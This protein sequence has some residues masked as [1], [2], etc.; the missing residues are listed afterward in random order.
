MRWEWLLVPIV[1]F[2]VT[3][4]GAGEALSPYTGQDKREIRAL[5]KEEVH[6]YLSGDGMGF[7]KTAELNHYPG[8]C[9]A[10]LS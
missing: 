3:A 6:G 2:Y 1:L 5:S 4:A 10:R 8:G 9:R 7:A